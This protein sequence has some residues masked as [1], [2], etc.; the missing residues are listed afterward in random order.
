ME[1]HKTV[2]GSVKDE[3]FRK[4]LVDAR[5]A[6]MWRIDE[7]GRSCARGMG[8]GWKLTEWRAGGSQSGEDTEKLWRQRSGASEELINNWLDFAL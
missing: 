4:R 3:G 2:C 5:E 7:A 8:V 6:R 1:R